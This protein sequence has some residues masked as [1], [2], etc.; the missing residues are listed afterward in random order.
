MRQSGVL[1]ALQQ[2]PRSKKVTHHPVSGPARINLTFRR[3]DPASAARA[4][5][6][7]C[8]NQA[9]LKASLNRQR[10]GGRHA[11]YFACDNTKGSCGFWQWDLES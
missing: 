7:R 8:G 1:Y 11:Y 5:L 2:V 9:V 4:P 6:C 3:L 10:P